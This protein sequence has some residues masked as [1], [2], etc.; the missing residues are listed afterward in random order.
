MSLVY[1]IRVEKMSLYWNSTC[2]AAVIPWLRLVIV[3]TCTPGCA[4]AILACVPEPLETGVTNRFSLIACVLSKYPLPLARA[5]SCSLSRSGF[6]GIRGFPGSARG[7][8]PAWKRASLADAA[9]LRLA[10]ALLESGK[11]ISLSCLQKHQT[12]PKSVTVLLAAIWKLIW[13]HE[14]PCRE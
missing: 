14:R 13:V 10:R 8:N 3:A 4:P 1:V 11:R 2:L 7:G 12:S 6:P 5:P 9:S